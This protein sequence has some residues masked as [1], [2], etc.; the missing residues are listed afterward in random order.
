[1]VPRHLP[2]DSSQLGA[3]L[4]ERLQTIG[5]AREFRPRELGGI[6][7][8]L[9]LGEHQNTETRQLCEMRRELA[10]R[11]G[12]GVRSPIV[13]ALRDALEHSSSDGELWLEVD[14]Q[15]IER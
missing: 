8:E 2:R 9:V 6:S 14:E 13:S 3:H 5:V 15:D 4:V 1:M 12:F 7:V 10:E 11:S